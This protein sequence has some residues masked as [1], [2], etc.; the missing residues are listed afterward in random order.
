[1]RQ[2]EELK[3]RLSPQPEGKILVG[4]SGGADSV[5]LIYLLLFLR[6]EGTAYPE[7]V[8]VNHGL[9]GNESEADEA[10]VRELCRKNEIPLHVERI[11]LGGRR[12][13]NRAREARYHAFLRVLK[14]NGIETLALAHQRDDQAETLLMHLMRGAG[15]EGLGGMRPLERR[16]EYTLIRPMLGISGKELRAALTDAGIAW[17]ED[18][19]N[20]E[21]YYLRNRIRKELIPLMEEMA[22][23]VS[24]RLARTAEL[25]AR[26]NEAA[27]AET[28]KMLSESA[29]V[30]GLFTAPLQEAAEAVRSR[31]LRA[32]WRKEGPLLEERELS[33]EQ[34]RR[35]EQLIDA[36]RGTIINLPGGWRA[37]REKDRL[38]LLDPENRTKNNRT[39]NEKRKNHD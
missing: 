29:A 23:G 33:F 37:R 21:K 9:R 39:R 25:M 32:W 22:P 1:M 16:E 38:R 26:E 28:R 15:P 13:E 11:D 5:A 12:D 14:E 31:V 7:A 6:E 35:L 18:A 17:R 36:P 27:A 8:H 19:S 4:L 34:T 30:E 24:D 10:F 3:R 2:L 20:Q